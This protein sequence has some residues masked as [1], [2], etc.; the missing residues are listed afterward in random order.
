MKFI[1]IIL[2]T[3]FI[4]LIHSA[5]SQDQAATSSSDIQTFFTKGDELG[6]IENSV[7]L[8]T[9]EVSLPVGLI[10]IPGRGGL[11]MGVS[12]MYNSNVEEISDTWN[13]E[14]PTGMLGLGWSME[15]PKIVVDNKMTGARDDDDFYL[16]EGGV[17]NKLHCVKINT[18]GTREYEPEQFTK[19]DI[20]YDKSDE[21]WTIVKE[22]GMTFIYGDD[23]LDYGSAVEYILHWDN[24]IGNSS[25]YS[26][27]YTSRQGLVWNLAKIKNRW[28]DVVT[29][30]YKKVERFIKNGTGI[31]HTEASYLE[32]ITG[33]VGRT[34][35]FIDLPKES[36]EYQ[37]PHTEVDELDNND[38]TGGSTG[39]AYQ[40][41][42]EKRY[43][44]NIEVKDSDNSLIYSFQFIYNV[45]SDGNL[46][47]RLL[48][49]IVQ[50]NEDGATY[51]SIDFSYKTS[52]NKKSALEKV[53]YPKGGEVTYHYN[54][55]GIEL[56]YSDRNLAIS[57]PSG[58]SEPQVWIGADYV[59]VAWRE[60]N[61]ST[62]VA[63]GKTVKLYAYTWDGEWKE[64]FRQ[65]IGSV[66]VENHK[67]KN[68][69]VVL[70]MDYFGVL[71]HNSSSHT[72]TLFLT[73]KS[74]HTSAGW[75]SKNVYNIRLG[76]DDDDNSSSGNPILIG[77]E[78]FVAVGKREDESSYD[79][80]SLYTYNWDGEDWRSQTIK[81]ISEGYYH[82]TGT[83]NYIIY[84]DEVGIQG[85]YADYIYFFYQDEEG[86]W[87]EKTV[88]SSYYFWSSDESYWYASNS[89]A[90]AMADDNNEFI[91]MWDENYN[92]TNKFD[93]LGGYADN[94]KVEILNNAMVAI[95]PTNPSKAR[96]ARFDGV[97]WIVNSEISSHSN[98]PAGNYFSFGEDVIF[99]PDYNQDLQ[100]KRYNAN[101]QSW[102]TGIYVN[103]DNNLLK[104]GQG[105]IYYDEDVYIRN[106]DES[107]SSTP[108]YSLP[109]GH[110]PGFPYYRSNGHNL[111]AYTYSN[112]TYV[113]WIKNGEATQANNTE[114]LNNKSVE[115]FSTFIRT[116]NLVS[117]NTV[118]TFPSTYSYMHDAT[119]ITLHRF[120]V[121][122]VSGKIK[123]Y[124]VEGIEINSGSDSKYIAINY[125]GDYGVYSEL[126]HG[127]MYNKVTVTHQDNSTEGGSFGHTEHYFIN[128]LS[129]S[130]SA[131]AFPSGG[132]AIS[133]YK[134]LRGQ[135]YLKRAIEGASTVV[136]EEKTSWEVFTKDIINSSSH[137]IAIGYFVRPDKTE[138]IAN[139]ISVTENYSY[140]SNT[141]NLTYKSSTNSEGQTVA[142]DYYYLHE[143]TDTD[144]NFAETD[145]LYA[146]V[147]QTKK[148]VGGVT[149]GG[150]AVDWIT[151]ETVNYPKETYV[152]DGP[153]TFTDFDYTTSTH[154]NWRKGST[155]TDIDS[156][157]NVIETKDEIND[158]YSA[159]IMGYDN[160]LPVGIV[161]NSTHGDSFVDVFE[162]E[163]LTNWTEVENGDGDTDWSVY[164]EQLKL[165]NYA[166][167]TNGECDRIY[168]DLG[169]EVT[170]DVVFEFDVTIA[171]SNSWDLTIGLG[172]YSWAT[173]N[174]GTENAVWTSINNEIW[175]YYAGGWYDIKTGLVIGNTYHFKIVAKPSTN[176]ADFYV[177][178]IKCITDG[179]FRYTSSGIQ[180]AAFGNYGYGTV[181][182]TWYIDNVRL[183]PADADIVSYDY[184]PLVGKTS[185]TDINN[186]K[187]TYTYDLFNRLET[188]RDGD[189]N[190]IKLT[191]YSFKGNGEIGTDPPWLDASP[192]SLSP[193]YSSGSTNSTITSNVNWVTSIS[194]GDED[195][196]SVSPLSGNNDGT[197]TISYNQNGSTS[198]R[199]GTVTL[200]GE[201][202][203]ETVNVTQSGAPGSLTVS[204]SAFYFEYGDNDGD[205]DITS[206]IS[207]TISVTYYGSDSGWLSFST[208]S[209][210][211]NATVNV[212]CS[213]NSQY[214]DYRE[215]QITVQGGGITR[216]VWVEYDDL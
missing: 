139:N 35:N 23:D 50:K 93:V 106:W 15:A 94:S 75:V 17:S 1:T 216:Y 187:I 164:N 193:T 19:W 119:Q 137:Q 213:T 70:G 200:A 29:F 64:F 173:G 208:T 79:D 177:D 136:S 174:G 166:S 183:Y 212:D 45:P 175:K 41:R 47:K 54:E 168:L 124:P 206:N 111:I 69:Q 33:P 154:T 202:L 201:G 167:A 26:S 158:V 31:R 190:I 151:N 77:G 59:V 141:G 96:V 114:I 65:T 179:N 150:S 99:W 112:D 121:D 120:I 127:G 180:K 66:E 207:W 110:E 144:Y 10:N 14:A 209:G 3:C 161:S 68:F 181:T 25:N 155:V 37:D 205:L 49:S 172:G 8:F 135:Q 125:D 149:L 171:N 188:V 122:G 156:Y 78:D 104:T 115:Y 146:S 194:S 67:L 98:S 142:E 215:A 2:F 62:H 191:E 13:V 6:Q 20:V 100:S 48:T 44:G 126:A 95:A 89:F 134:M 109:S 118:V 22:D 117:G 74:N 128:G 148:I 5:S 21:R 40:E 131:I 116:P 85:G 86:E 152:W 38:G 169:S 82:G 133:K 61:G 123:E 56:D 170:N 90:V 157:G 130:E 81:S 39:D 210:T 60:Y 145:N 105:N 18:D 184:M 80:G 11:G 83:N 214:D 143:I 182:T 92:M 73:H 27:S 4:F 24:W 102:L 97:T 153:G 165:I 160:A 52:G 12:L 7:N 101:T 113:V 76:T 71:T 16:V 87:N 176:K 58:Y 63:T 84:H 129:S 30:E 192:T 163:S 53:T 55:T 178:G 91:Y 88:S 186:Q 197:I 138:V 42:Y 199:N 195:W 72:G 36:R 103:G 204:P 203:T 196:L 198:S 34:I 46:T 140:D 147:V 108:I 9:G 51:P 189:G 107:W 159:K 132:N 162:D 43:L 28:G 211:G 32:K 57:A 185:E